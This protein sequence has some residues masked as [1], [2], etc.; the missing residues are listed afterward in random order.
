MAAISAAS[1]AR[2][3]DASGETFGHAQARLN[4]AQRQQAAIGREGPT[5][6]RALIGLP[7]TGGRPGRGSVAWVSAGMVSGDGRVLGSQP[8][9]MLFNGLRH[10]RQP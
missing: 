3:I 6:E 1:R 5:V 10:A 8:N 9:P 2:I 4:L 7:S